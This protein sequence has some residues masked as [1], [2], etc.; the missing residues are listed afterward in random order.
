MHTKFLNISLAAIAVC[1]AGLLS[2]CQK[3]EL[4]GQ[5]EF[6][7]HVPEN[8]A[9]EEFSETSFTISWDYVNGATSYTVQLV[10]MDENPTEGTIY[11]TTD[12]S[13]HAFSFSQDEI[14]KGTVNTVWY[15][16][17]R[18][19][20]PRNNYV[21]ITGLGKVRITPELTV[22]KAT[23]S[24]LTYEWSFTEDAASDAADSYELCLYSDEAC[25]NLVVGW[26]INGD[27]G[28]F[29]TG[30]GDLVRFTFS[31]LG[32]MPPLHITQKCATPLSEVSSLLP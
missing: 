7:S 10:D 28:I 5:E 24:S 9:L 12:E 30:A 8:V 18:A 26:T 4:Y 11:T 31:G 15:A 3:D 29:S 20:F 23:S 13:A 22:L 1:S 25:E 2:S 17:V 19:N 27:D 14:D 32:L 6:L 21:L 16:R